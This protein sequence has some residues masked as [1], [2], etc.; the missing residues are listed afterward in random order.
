MVY[1]PRT[2]REAVDAAGLVSFEVVRAETDLHVSASRD[3]SREAGALVEQLRNDLESYIAAH[4]RFAESF[5][6]VEVEPD[7]PEIVR[8]MAAAARSADV[9][10]MAAVAGA[11]AERVA[12]GLAVLS[13]EVIVENGGDLYLMGNTP[14][15]AL[16]QAG[17]S[18][19]SGRIA[20]EIRAEELPAALCTSSGTVGHSVSLGAAHATTILADDGAFADAAATAI[21]N[22][23]HGPD[24]IEAAVAHGRA[25]PG[26]RGVVIVAGERVGAAGEIH[27]VRVGA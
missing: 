20:L 7:A 23:V 6:P 16:L 21:G 19:L 9:G 11:V 27:L 14:R 3:L 1:E 13:P 18:P 17:D 2:Y 25:M 8:A 4:P 26:V 22:L 24:D 10:P 15:T 12:R 5:V